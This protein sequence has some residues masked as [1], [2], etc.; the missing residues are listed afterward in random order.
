VNAGRYPSLRVRFTVGGYNA[1]EWALVDTGFDGDFAVP[2]SIIG[3]LSQP[4]RRDRVQTASGQRVPVPIF[5]S[6]IELVDL[7][8]PFRAEIIAIG[9]EYLLGIHALN[10]FKVTFD[11]G[12]RVIVEP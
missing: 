11:H 3:S 1:E 6:M 10:R 12:Q 8:G 2:Q 9:D 5:P 4:R 7:P